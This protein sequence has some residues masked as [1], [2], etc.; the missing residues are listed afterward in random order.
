MMAKKKRVS[1]A[2]RLGQTVSDMANAASVAATSSE[3]GVLELAAED[4]LSPRPVERARKMSAASKKKMKPAPK[5]RV[6]AKKLSKPKKGKRAG[7]RR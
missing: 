1:F 5:K 2:D 4:E 7:K 6:V 3:I